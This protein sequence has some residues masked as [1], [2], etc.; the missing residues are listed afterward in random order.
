MKFPYIRYGSF[1]RPVIPIAFAAHGLSF[2]Y[3]ALIDTGADISIV[4]AEIAEQLGLNLSDGEQ[5]GF[6]G[7]TGIGIGYKHNVAINIGDL[8][9][10]N[11]PVVFSD[12]I[13]PQGLGI[14]GHEGL[15]DRLRLV[16]EYGKY[17]IEITQ[18]RYKS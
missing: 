18:K 2:P 14:L 7:I 16:F 3:R 1:Y 17:E 9:L 8:V 6:G 4:H 12:E 10:P 13:A 15:F 11:V 5:T